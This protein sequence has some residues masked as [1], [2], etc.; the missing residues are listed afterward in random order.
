MTKFCKINDSPL[1]YNSSLVSVK[2]QLL[3]SN[4]FVK[5]FNIKNNYRLLNQINS[6][7]NYLIIMH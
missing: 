6:T 7:S 2:L 4:Y 1:E 5:K 3:S